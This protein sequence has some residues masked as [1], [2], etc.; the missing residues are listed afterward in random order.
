MD[1]KIQKAQK[2]QLPLLKSWEQKQGVRRNSRVLHMPP[3]HNTTKVTPL[4]QP[5]TAPCP[6]PNKEPTCPH[7]G[8]T[9][10]TYCL[11]APHCCSRGHSKALPECLLWPLINF[12]WLMRPRALVGNR[13]ASWCSCG[14]YSRW[15]AWICLHKIIQLSLNFQTFIL[16][17][18][19]KIKSYRQSK[20]FIQ[21]W[22]DT[23][24]SLL[25]LLPV[26]PSQQQDDCS[27]KKQ[28]FPKLV[29]LI[30]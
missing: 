24:T 19:P 7:S 15:Q 23:C 30:T 3:A 9:K 25:C 20:R 16:D 26:I 12:Y 11:F 8:R 2:A 29:F 17:P 6:H 28:K 18:W 5:L 22:S 13:E 4:V 27:N 21:Q 1:S 10:E 14:S